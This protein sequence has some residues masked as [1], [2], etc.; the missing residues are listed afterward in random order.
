MFTWG[1][2]N[3]CTGSSPKV[4]VASQGSVKLFL[5]SEGKGRSRGTASA[6]RFAFPDGN[7]ESFLFQDSKNSSRLETICANGL[8]T[9]LLRVNL[10][11]TADRRPICSYPLHFQFPYL[12]NGDKYICF[13]TSQWPL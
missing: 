6:T 2:S 12:Q 7:A 5:H 13:S 1:T 3:S 9:G 10:E 8:C 4:T 11:F